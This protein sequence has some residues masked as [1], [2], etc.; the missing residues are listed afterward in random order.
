MPEAVHAV[1]GWYFR[2][3]YGPAEG[4]GVTP[5]YCDPE[6]VG[7]FAVAP[8]ELAAGEPSALF[9]LF[10]ALSMYQALRD[11]VI[12]RQQRTLE[13]SA[14]RGL[15]DLESLQAAL[16]LN[17]CGA[18][19]SG[20][21]F[22]AV[23]DVA[24]VGTR[25]DCGQRPGEPCHVKGATI[26]FNRMGDLGKLPTSA[27]FRVWQAG[28]P[29][30]LE[31]VFRSEPSPTRRAELLVVR[32]AAVHRVGRKLATM[33]VSALSTPAL[34]PGLTPWFPDVDGNE[35][36]VVDTN[37]ARVADAL[38][39]ADA[40]K[41]YDARERWVRDQAAA[42][43]LGQVR[44]GL[45]SYSPRLV[46]QTL[47]AYASRSNRSARRDPC[48]VRTTPCPDCVP[49]L[50]PFHPRPHAGKSAVSSSSSRPAAK[51]NGVAQST[52]VPLRFEK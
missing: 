48:S 1:V 8:Q 18:L 45:P 52:T 44:S 34:A 32:F 41:S 5:F 36:V 9:R 12:R 2:E 37:L 42:V 43:D 7:A 33:F 38:R 13:V 51:N 20:E 39:P 19:R 50:C 10:V 16:A 24:K 49:L 35:L 26:S 30:T 28:L 40:P 23:C 14:V 11:V 21:A 22:A 31:A 15:A 27:W 17:P 6:Q 29:A 25:V 46:Q 3:V 4:A 47:Y